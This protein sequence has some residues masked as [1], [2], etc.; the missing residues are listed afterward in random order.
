VAKCD[1][2]AGVGAGKHE[3]EQGKASLFPFKIAKIIRYDDALNPNPDEL[4]LA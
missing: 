2:G 3:Q 1:G 4:A